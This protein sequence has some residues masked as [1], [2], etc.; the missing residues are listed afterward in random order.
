MVSPIS[1]KTREAVKQTNIILKAKRVI[2]W[3][4]DGVIKDSVK[5]KSEGYEQLFL[6]YGE[7][8]VEKVRLHHKVHGG[9]SRYE[10]IPLYLSWADE[11]VNEDLIKNFCDKFSDLVQQA[12]VD[13]PWV[14]GVQEYLQA[15][16]T[17]QYFFLIT[18]TPQK[19]IEQILHALD[20]TNCFREVHGAPV[21]KVKAMRDVLK[22]VDCLPEQALMVGDSETDL[23][24]AGM[25]NVPFLL[26]CT[27]FNESLQQRSSYPMFDDLN[28]E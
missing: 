7:D 12:V 24:A 22:R 15:N 5:V 17:N 25:N 14:P 2:F 1:A 13:S 26:R 16:H 23:R 10:K 11:S 6:S 27:Q 28:Y 20:I 8:V 9:I 21:A 4:F 3:D 19:E 18:A